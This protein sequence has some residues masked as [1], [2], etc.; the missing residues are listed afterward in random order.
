M[1]LSVVVGIKG[2]YCTLLQESNFACVHTFTNKVVP[3]FSWSATK[4]EAINATFCSDKSLIEF[5][6]NTRLFIQWCSQGDSG[7]FQACK[8]ISAAFS[9]IIIV[10]EL[11]L[12]DVMVGMMDASTTRKPLTPLTR[13]SMPTTA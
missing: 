9:A 8:I 13:K 1:L 2:S 10:G 12:P 7:V 4:N 11:V 3:F 5:K 6:K